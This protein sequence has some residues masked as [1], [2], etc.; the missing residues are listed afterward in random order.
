[1]SERLY[2]LLLLL[3]PA[4][5]RK[6]HGDE[7]LQLFR[8]R[9][10]DE[11]GFFPRLLLWSNLILDLAIS[12]P[13]EYRRARQA[14]VQMSTPLTSNPALQFRLLED[15]GTPSP[16]AFVSA[17]V[18]AVA[19][20]GLLVTVSTMGGGGSHAANSTGASKAAQALQSNPSRR[21][22]GMAGSENVHTSSSRAATRPDLS[23]GVGVERT[24]AVLIK[25]ENATD[26]MLQAFETHDVVMFGEVH[27]SKQEYEW[28]CHLVNAPGFADRVDDIVVEFGNARYQKIVD[29]YVAGD[30]VPSDQVQKAWQNMV[31]DA[32]PVS[33]V[34]GWFYRAV[35]EANLKN[36]H[37]RIRLIM[38]SPPADWSRIRTANDL[39]PFEADRERW[40]VQQVKREVIAEHHH[41]LLIMGA[42]HFLRGHVQALQD[43]LAI[44]QHRPVP[45]VNR[46][47]LQP[48]YIEREL[49]AAGA[50]PYIVVLGS[51]V[52]DD[53][54]DIDPR[55]ASW[56][57]PAMV[58]L[59]GGWV[60]NLLAEPVIS[61]GHA[62]ATPL[63][64]ADEA[65]AMLYVAPC[66]DLQVLFP[67]RSAVE[68]TPYG[69][70]LVRRD[71][72]L[73]GH[74]L[75]F[76]Y[77]AMPQCVQPERKSQ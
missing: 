58:P 9:L 20:F 26:A 64:L 56:S 33:P 52:I 44:Q 66:S 61:D 72:I 31:A 18:I 22:S 70:E 38:G 71:M 23:A 5:F 51:N 1:M 25:P 14:L 69:E 32:A 75:D 4:H 36:P 29:R 48:G 47:Q 60:G 19:A 30:D 15:A 62:P 73:V 12:L 76:Q 54:G 28:L 24:P 74:K 59:A 41:A 11:S 43:E 35:R 42:G 40:Y 16:R 8:D 34:Y 57:V 50:N 2:A 7:A 27:G 6:A 53:R 68:G 21:D 39:A 49:R 63:T 10:R 55:F 37:H 46:D 45:S 67:P 77:G 65:D 17:S 3:Y 13:H